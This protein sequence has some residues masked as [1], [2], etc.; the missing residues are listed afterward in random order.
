MIF[1]LIRYISACESTWRILA[2][3]TH[4]RTTPVE[5]LTFHLEGEQ[6]V[7]YREG[8]TVETVMARMSV[9][10]TMF[11]AWFVCNEEYPEA[12][13]LTYAEM[14]TKFL[15]DSKNQIWKKRKKRFAIGRL[16]HVSPSSGELYFLRVLI[17][18]IKGPRSYADIKTVDGVIQP[19]FEDACYKL[20][21]LDEDK[22]YIEG[23]KECS[24]WA[25]GTYV[26]KF[27]VQ[28]LLSESLSSP[29]KVWEATKDL[30]SEDI[31]FI[32]RKKRGNPS[33]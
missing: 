10:K 29:N 9:S 15:Y 7:I 33:K 12:R 27:F 13:L 21:L 25:T 26:R 2:F 20:G 3:P 1:F 24:F 11:L 6:P 22:E 8:D 30:L 4:F 23:L 14:P 16:Q 32:E 17:N 18:K 19:S 31:L 5:K 28:M